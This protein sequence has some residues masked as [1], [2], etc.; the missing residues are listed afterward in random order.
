MEK[1]RWGILSTAN[2]AR[3]EVIPAIKRADNA[4]LVGI[5][6]RDEKVYR[7][8][9]ELDITKAFASYEELLKD[10]EIDAVYIPLPN[11]LHKEWVNKAAYYGKHILCEKPVALNVAE[12]IDMVNTCAKNNVKFME[13]FMYQFHPQHERVRE[14]I[15]EGAIGEVKLFKSS[16]SFYLKNREGDIRMN[17]EMG[18]GSIYD[19]GC[20]SIH[21][22]RSILKAEPESIHGFAEIDSSSK[23]DTSAYIHMVMDNKV[24]VLIDCSFDMLERNEY[25]VIGT[26]GKITV[27][28]AFRPDRNGGVGEI[29]LNAGNKTITEKISGDIYKF[30]IE[31][32]S[33]CILQDTAPQNSGVDSINNMKAIQSCYNSL[34][35]HLDLI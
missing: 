32:F 12:T 22:A 14:L 7:I 27:P 4:E 18:G 23:V 5:A 20:Y 29:I 2:I 3:T 8:A 31:H 1:V 17:A 9:K 26:K 19:V 34:N 28:Y 35:N 13:A 24:P 25:E 30:E 11:H 21:A 6:S 33:Q 16:H 15:S 10:D